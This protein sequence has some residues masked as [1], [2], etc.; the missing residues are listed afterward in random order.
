MGCARGAV[1]SVVGCAMYSQ[2]TVSST[3]YDSFYDYVVFPF[4]TLSRLH[5]RQYSGHVQLQLQLSVCDSDRW[6]SILLI[7]VPP[8][9]KLVAEASSA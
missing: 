5:A 7:N 9:P 2:L 6:Y 8:T 1:D 3:N 4:V